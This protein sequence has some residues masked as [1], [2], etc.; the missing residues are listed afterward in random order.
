MQQFDNEVGK[1]RRIDICVMKASDAKD[2]FLQFLSLEEKEKKRE[3]AKLSEKLINNSWKTEVKQWFLAVRDK[4]GQIIGKIEVVP[5]KDG[6][7]FFTIEMAN[8]QWILKYGDEAVDQF[9]KICKERKY[10]S[11]IEFDK[12][13]TIIE[14]YRKVHNLGTYEFKIA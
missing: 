9:I 1:R 3:T 4:S 7:A 14:H 5:L 6:N 10:F 8:Q 12:E 13:N 2:Y 11:T